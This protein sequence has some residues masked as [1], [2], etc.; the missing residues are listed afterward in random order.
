MLTNLSKLGTSIRRALDHLTLT[1][2]I[3]R[4]A[5]AGAIGF[6][7]IL[8]LAA[9]APAATDGSHGKASSSAPQITLGECRLESTLPFEESRRI[10][11]S[12]GQVIVAVYEDAV[13]CCTLQVR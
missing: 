8:G 6:G 11:C 7:L 3:A 10:E 13:R 2:R 9:T 4:R 1:G 12:A 5:T